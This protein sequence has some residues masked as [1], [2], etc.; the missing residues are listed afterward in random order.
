MLHTTL[1][2][3]KQ[4]EACTERY[5]SLL[6]KLG[7][8]KKYGYDTPIMID[9][10]VEMNGLDDSL[11]ALRAT[12]K[13]QVK[14]RDFIARIFAASCADHA[15]SFYEKKYPT[16]MRLR[17]CIEASCLYA[18]R[19]FTPEE[20]AAAREAAWE[21]ARD[22]AWAAAWAAAREAARAAAWAAAREAETD[23]QK[24]LFLSLLNEGLPEELR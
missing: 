2:L 24:A 23:W 14:E 4:N 6:K 9:R 16:D 18:W 7:G 21:A 8:A 17:F 1:N 15:L 3:L 5:R 19:D 22:A 11:W 12:P 20:L 13:D 10:L